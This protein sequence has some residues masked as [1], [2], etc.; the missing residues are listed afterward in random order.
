MNSDGSKQENL[1]N[2]KEAENNPGWSPDGTKIVY[3]R[4]AKTGNYD[5]EYHSIVEIDVATNILRRSI[6]FKEEQVESPT[7]SPDGRK[8]IFSTWLNKPSSDDPSIESTISRLNILDLNNSERRII[9]EEEIVCDACYWNPFMPNNDEIYFGV[10]GDGGMSSYAKINLKTKKESSVEFKDIPDT[11]DYFG[12]MAI[13]NDNLAAGIVYPLDNGVNSLFIRDL[14]NN[15]TVTMLRDACVSSLTPQAFSIDGKEIVFT[16]TPVPD[17][18]NFSDAWIM[19]INQHKLR[20]IADN[21]DSPA[22]QPLI[23]ESKDESQ[24]I[25]QDKSGNG[26]NTIEKNV[27]TT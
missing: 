14:K 18:F 6:T 3:A 20:K 8:L 21:A 15:K 5:A 25:K 11:S 12:C 4:G 17:N 19:N 10:G 24:N 23:L 26:T 7:Y 2:S 1:T 22:W 9:G 13:W 27:V 16:K